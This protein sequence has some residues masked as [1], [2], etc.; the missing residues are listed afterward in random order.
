MKHTRVNLL[1][2]ILTYS[3]IDSKKLIG[4]QIQITGSDTGGMKVTQ[5]CI[6]FMAKKELF[7]ETKLIS[8]LDE[9][10]KVDEELTKGTASSLYRYVIDIGK[11]LQ[12]F[13]KKQIKKSLFYGQSF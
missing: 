7:V 6:D 12:F 9:L 8:N 13:S 4:D 1:F 11:L 10:Q 3:Q 2:S 5:E